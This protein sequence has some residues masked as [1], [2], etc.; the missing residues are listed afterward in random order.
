MSA[1]SE[2][3]HHFPEVLIVT[4]L[5]L[6]GPRCVRA[7]SR[8][9]N[10][11]C[12]RTEK[13][14][15]F[16]KAP[17]PGEAPSPTPCAAQ[18]MPSRIGAL[19]CVV[20]RLRVTNGRADNMSGTSEVAQLV[21]LHDD[22]LCATC[23]SAEAGQLRTYDSATRLTH[24]AQRPRLDASFQP[25]KVPWACETV[26]TIDANAGPL[27]RCTQSRALGAV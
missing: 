7:C 26:P 8:Q 9:K 2:P 19:Q 1:A 17:T 21:L 15:L 13:A 11:R 5:L 24:L 10:G 4:T 12:R 20:W 16:L 3:T 6:Y 23:K 25:W 18:S 22:P 27:G 14:G